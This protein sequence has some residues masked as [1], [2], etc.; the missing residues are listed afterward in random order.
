MVKEIVSTEQRQNKF[1]SVHIILFNING[2]PVYACLKND[3]MHNYY[4]V[5][6]ITIRMCGESN[7]YA[8]IL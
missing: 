5:I 7:Y 1:Y 8:I 4:T 6:S 2:V 3:H